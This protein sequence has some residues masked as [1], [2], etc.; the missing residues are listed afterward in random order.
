MRIFT[1]CFAEILKQRKDAP[2]PARITDNDTERP[3]P[4]VHSRV[5]HLRV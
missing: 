2:D 3:C 5:G 1:S 4:E